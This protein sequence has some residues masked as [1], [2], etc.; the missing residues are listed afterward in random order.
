MRAPRSP[1]SW[2]ERK[3]HAIFAE[4]SICDSLETRVT[5]DVPLV[6]GRSRLGEGRAM[7]PKAVGSRAAVADITA[8]RHRSSGYG[9]DTADPEVPHVGEP[10]PAA[11]ALTRLS[12]PVLDDL[13]SQISDTS[14]ALVMA[15]R[16][17][18][19][20]RRDAMSSR[21]RRAMDDRSLDIGFSLAERDVGTNG[22]GTSLETRRPTFV[23]GDQ[24]YS[25]SFHGFTCANALVVHPITGKVEATV[26]V[27]CPVEDTS[28]LLLPT[29][30]RLANQISDLLMEQA[31][32]Q[33]R[34]LLE[35]FLLSRR[36]P[37]KAI[38]AIGDGV[39][40]ATTSAQRRLVG[41]DH[42]ELWSHVQGA[43]GDGG[44][45]ETAFE[46]PASDRL[47]L[48]C[49]PLVRNGD[50]EGATVE[51]VA[52]PTRRRR[53]RRRGAE[54]LGSLVGESPAWARV[55]DDSVRAGQVD[56]PVLIVGERGSGRRSVADAIAE[57]RSRVTPD[58]LSSAELVVDGERAWLR[59]LRR[60]L[61]KPSPTILTHV[62]QLP[63][64]VAAAVAAMLD[65][66][67]EA[68][69]IGT[70]EVVVD[71]GP[72]L[73]GLLD[74]MRVVQIDIPPLRERSEDIAP[75][76]RHLAQRLGHPKLGEQVIQELV[77]QPWPGNVTELDRALRS[78][79]VRAR[80]QPLEVEHLP[81]SARRSNSCV[82]LRGLRK[83]E[84]EAIVAAL[85]ES[86]TRTE[87]AE[88]LGISRATLFRRIKTYGLIVAD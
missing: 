80:S 57:R 8:A 69:I 1:C 17:G 33:E 64:N 48:R 21:T 9:L 77:R 73:S 5:L 19:L 68:S 74:R 61:S 63:D 79:A 83:Q 81:R 75:L 38:A 35:Q 11:D 72:G 4:V 40:I 39:V 87:A 58:V 25:E 46:G 56:E 30:L 62:D 49:H 50:L 82:P 43:L 7:S 66:A 65:Q 36:S 34:F 32:P 15:D 22:V 28:A 10:G 59:R 67:P 2:P 45:V 3:L 44:V 6:R 29:A 42:L 52:T 27:M 37:Q 85:D 51:F 12:A 76:A 47:R 23:V 86:A 84:A 60:A 20:T 71:A 24:H 18:R 55:V 16:E 26:G 88:R 31:T 78:A 53:G 54:R 70:T 41:V 13:V 14:L